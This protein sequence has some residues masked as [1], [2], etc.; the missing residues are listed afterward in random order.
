MV[1]LIG[2][3]RSYP[4]DAPDEV[5]KRIGPIETYASCHRSEEA[6]VRVP[7]MRQW[8]ALFIFGQELKDRC[9]I[10][11]WERIRQLD[12]HP[13]AIR[14]EGLV[15]YPFLA[16]PLYVRNA[17]Y[18]ADQILH[19]VAD[20]Q[21]FGVRS[22]D[23]PPDVGTRGETFL[24]LLPFVQQTSVTPTERFIPEMGRG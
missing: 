23:T 17:A 18:T 4:F 7:R 22:L 15:L 2:E 14:I 24:H 20:R 3:V 16:K 6:D 1:S 9:S 21:S 11:A 19:F 8:V 5:G 10:D 13:K 12:I